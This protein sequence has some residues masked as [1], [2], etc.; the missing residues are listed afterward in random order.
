MKGTMLLAGVLLASG[1]HAAPRATTAFIDVNL[2]AMAD[3]TVQPHQVVLVRDGRIAA[4]GP[5]GKVT[6]PAGARRV[7]AAGAYLAPGL[8]DMH[9]HMMSPVDLTLFLAN[10]VTTVFNLH[11]KPAHLMWRAGVAGGKLAGPRIYSTGPIINDPQTPQAA[12]AM[13]DRIADAGYDGIKIYNRVGAAEYPALIA[14]AKQRG[15]LLMG[16]V[17][18]G[19]G[20]AATLAAGQSIAHAEEILYTNFAAPDGDDLGRMRLDDAAIPALVQR[21]AQSGVSVTPTLSMFHD[22]HRQATDLPGYL[23]DP[24]YRYLAP[25]QLAALQPGVNRY[26]KRYDAAALKFLQDG[27]VFQQRLVKAMQ[28]AGVPLLAGTD[29][30]QIGPIAGFS[31]HQELD[32]LVAAGLTPYQA[33]R[34]ATVNPAAYLKSDAGTLAVGK[35]ADMVLAACNPLADVT[36]LR[37][38]DGVVAGGRWFDGAR[39]KAMLADVPAAHLRNR[40]R[41]T[42]TLVAHPEQADA[43]LLYA[44][45][46]G[47]LGGAV[48]GDA[49]DRL[50]AARFEKLVAGLSL[51]GREAPNM[52]ALNDLGYALLA[53]KR[54]PAAI[55]LMQRNW[56][57]FPREANAA[58]SLADAY[59]QSGD[60]VRAR[61]YYARALALDAKYVNADFANKFLA[62]HPAAG[63]R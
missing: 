35:R 49:Y 50:G 1:V 4:I 43:A 8:H 3:D 54:Y 61:D 6:I 60:A 22:I 5:L 45:P 15:L 47:S 30:T 40:R 59:L 39:V 13:V 2:V 56:A 51:A 10:G 53:N 11:G 18:R 28:Q 9:V 26:D 48:L 23:R 38:L 14:E 33:L 20:F 62:E 32:E 21:I 41:L 12:V 17:A 46:L 34:A 27:Y 29:A 19:P 25:W 55:A 52:E 57:L 63:S 58:D 37:K 36:C 7:R 44:D 42:A 31:L 16:H 24:R